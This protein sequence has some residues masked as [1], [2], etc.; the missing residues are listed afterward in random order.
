[1]A[2]SDPQMRPR[3]DG[4]A[5]GVRRQWWS[6]PVVQFVA[7]GLIA[8]IVLIVGS[9]ELSQRA[10]TKE[11]IIDARATTGLLSEAVVQPALSAGLVGGQA[12]AVD[13]FDR[14]ARQRLLVGDVLR[15]KIWTNGGKIIYSDEARLIGKQFALDE[16]ERDILLNG[17]SAAEV[18]DLSRPENRYEQK[19]GRLLE[20]YTQ[21]HA[22]KGRPLLFE[23]YFSYEDISR[24]SAEVL[25]AF[26]PITVVGLLAFL[27]LTGSLVWV[28]ARRLD[29]AAAERERLLV[30]AVNASDAERRRIA[31]DLHDGV[32]QELAGISFAMSATQREVSD[33]PEVASRLSSLGSGVRHS[34]RVLRS[35]LVEIYPPNLRTEGLAAA[36]DDLLAP[37]A[38]S[39]VEV[40]LNVSDT[41]HLADNTTALVWRVAQE[42]VRNATRHGAPTHINVSVQTSGEAAR[43][44]VSDNG[45]GFNPFEL[46]AHGHFGLRGLRDLVAEAGGQLE[47]VSAPGAGTRVRLEV[48]PR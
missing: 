14:L 38:A 45:V 22:P 39:G 23:A 12:A 46:P 11:A 17:G 13:K 41:A 31:R 10:A 26:R 25:D 44:E 28:L 47:V 8:L 37:V 34:L 27:V 1:M 21:A 33:R 48:S 40:H 6:N 2:Q 30:A 5:S 32:V 3:L 43:L 42:A 35:L 9:G 4:A 15:V 7:V 18:S 19:F 36:L 16:E 29:A 20:V 24:R